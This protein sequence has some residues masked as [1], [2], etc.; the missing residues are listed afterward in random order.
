MSLILLK[1]LQSV[2]YFSPKPELPL[3]DDRRQFVDWI[4]R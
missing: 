4:A 3:V 1:K 2:I